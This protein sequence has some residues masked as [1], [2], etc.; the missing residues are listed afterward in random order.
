MTVSCIIITSAISFFP[1]Y[2]TEALQVICG[3]LNLVESF[4]IDNM[5]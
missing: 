2:V 5:N 4:A 3:L 1:P